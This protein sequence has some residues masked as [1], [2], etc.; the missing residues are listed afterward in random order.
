MRRTCALLERILAVV[1]AALMAV[2]AFTVILQVSTR[3]LSKYV[4]SAVPSTPWT[5][6]VAGF[7]LAWVALLGA[8]YAYR[9]R[10]HVGDDYFILKMP[11]GVRRA[12]RHSVFAVEIVF[13]VGILG[14]GGARLAAITFQLGQES[15]V[16][17]WPMGAV[18]LVIPLSGAMMTL[19]AA[20]AW[21]GG[22]RE[23]GK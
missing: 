15:S 4:S 10:L 23:I 14:Y 7:L 22:E 9:K 20:D 18:Y 6:E 11:A 16:L 2:I 13:F 8:A 5:E 17:H 1:L 12:V 21:I 3:L 19:F